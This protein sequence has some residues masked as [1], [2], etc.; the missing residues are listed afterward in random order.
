MSSGSGQLAGRD[1]VILGQRYQVTGLLGRGRLTEV[2]AGV[3]VSSGR[4]VVVKR[5]LLDLAG[6]PDIRA[7]FSAEAELAAMIVHPN[8]VSILDTNVHQGVPYVVVERLGGETLGDHLTTALDPGWVRNLAT[9]ALGAIEAAHAAGLAHGS[10]T[11]G[12]ILLGSDGQAKVDDFCI[13]RSLAGLEKA[14]SA[15]EPAADIEAMGRILYRALTGMS[16]G[17]APAPL[18]GLVPDVDPA[19]ARAVDR[20]VL[21]EP[22]R[23]F[24]SAGSMA[25]CLLGVPDP[26][27]PRGPAY[28]PTPVSS[29]VDSPAVAPAPVTPAPVTTPVLVGGAPPVVVPAVVRPSVVDEP[30]SSEIPSSDP[31]GPP[32]RSP[33]MKSP[34]AGPDESDGA[35]FPAGT[36]VDERWISGLDPFGPARSGWAR[37]ERASDLAGSDWVTSDLVG[38]AGPGSSATD[39][40][41]LAEGPERT[42]PHRGGD[43]PGGPGWGGIASEEQSDDDARSATSGPQAEGDGRAA[44]G[45]RRS[46]VFDHEL[47]V[48]DFG[49]ADVGA[50]DSRDD[51]GCTDGYGP[52]G[53][54]V[55]RQ[56]STPNGVGVPTKRGSRPKRSGST[57]PRSTR[58]GSKRSRSTLPRSTRSGSKR[59]R[60]TLPRSTRSGAGRRASDWSGSNRSGSG[61]TRSGSGSNRSD[62]ARSRPGSSYE[63]SGRRARAPRG[64][65][66]ALAG[67]VLVAAGL[68]AW[69]I[70]TARQPESGRKDKP[71]GA[72]SASDPV[73]RRLMAVADGLVPADG[74]RSGDL[75]KRLRA[76]AED[77]DSAGSSAD[78]AELSAKVDSWVA[79]GG[80]DV[81]AAGPARSILAEVAGLGAAGG[82]DDAGLVPTPADGP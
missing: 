80:L 42:G 47:E 33:W 32:A 56:R 65:A 19:M 73:G 54:T 10:V 6:R 39:A 7:R 57:L 64:Y 27:A 11:P 16:P 34:R 14:Y 53:S 62:S 79:D 8:A 2:F 77:I 23:G 50:G 18:A 38:S 20:A 37:P 1:P 9:E 4:D 72:Q 22:G 60:S 58:S 78:A 70:A 35:P 36:P 3:D 26:G 75:A 67:A 63:H 30:S 31:V 24:A 68:G 48:G 59:S 71:G 21:A 29:S 81:V 55:R 82:I 74:P 66:L 44:D 5:L 46:R 49:D 40:E 61:S 41:T 13:G 25:A 17:V 12:N 69:A 51:F 76:L 52:A 43:F 15:A 28:F 45:G